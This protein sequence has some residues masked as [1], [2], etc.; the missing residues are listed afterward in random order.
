[1]SNG[2]VTWV[3]EVKLYTKCSIKIKDFPFDSQCCEI[4]FYSWA[5]TSRQ[6]T[7]KQFGNKHVTNLSHLRFNIF[8]LFAIISMNFV[9][10][11]VY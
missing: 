10:F 11:F 1:M 9:I 8:I 7:I 2:I 5:H 6:M 4:N 3:P